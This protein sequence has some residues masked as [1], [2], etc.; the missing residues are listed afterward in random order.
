MKSMGIWDTNA[1]SDAS[2][3]QRSKKIWSG[4]E[5]I[6]FL[7]GFGSD[8]C[9]G[10]IEDESR[11]YLDRSEQIEIATRRCIASLVEKEGQDKI[12]NR[13]VH[14]G[15]APSDVLAAKAFAERNENDNLCVG[16]VAVATGSY[17][18]AE[19][20]SLIGDPLPG[21]WEPVVL[22]DGMN[23]PDFLKHCGVL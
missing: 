4:T 14:I 23:D 9:S 10:L 17:D 11:N 1:L 6:A 20:E 3:E 19:L 7:G 18:F 13:V 15:D 2:K 22:K 8:F 21:R 16:L 5:D 12:L